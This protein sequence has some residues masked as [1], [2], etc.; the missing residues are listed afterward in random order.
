MCTPYYC[1]D[2]FQNFLK[3]IQLQYLSFSEWKFTTLLHRTAQVEFCLRGSPQEASCWAVTLPGLKICGKG[4]VCESFSF[5]KLTI[6]SRLTCWHF[7]FILSFS[8]C[9]SCPLRFQCSYFGLSIVNFTE[10]WRT[11]ALSQVTGGKWFIT[12]VH[13]QSIFQALSA[14]VQLLAN[15]KSKSSM[16]T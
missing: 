15:C 7:M 6:T 11:V 14:C 3:W 10:T 4:N 13:F 12:L 9:N 8:C 1:S 5:G 2:F 16:W